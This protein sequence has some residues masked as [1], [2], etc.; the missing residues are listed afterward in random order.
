MARRI[1][2]SV[3]IGGPSYRENQRLLAA[4][5]DM[6]TDELGW[7]EE[8]EHKRTRTKPVHVLNR[9]LAWLGRRSRDVQRQILIEGRA[10]EAQ[11]LASDT[12]FDYS[13][14]VIE[15]DEPNNGGGEAQEPARKPR[16]RA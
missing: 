14:A 2:K 8:G 3:S 6:A 4:L 7:T 13:L 15:P 5:A 16:R 11:H 9:V 1:S 10:I 12:P